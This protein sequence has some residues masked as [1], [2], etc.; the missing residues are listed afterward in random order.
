MADDLPFAEFLGR[1]RAGDGEAARELVRRYEP[2]IRREV[3][4][5]IGDDRLNRAFDSVDVSQSVLA[6]FFTRAA[7]GN[8]QIDRFEQ[9]AMLLM[10]MARNKLA[11]RARSER[12]LI[13]DSRRLS[14]KTEVLEHVV[15]AGPSPSEYLARR[16]EIA[17]L[18]SVLSDEER[19]IYELRIEGLSWDEIAARLGGNG[20]ARRM[21]FSRG[22]QRLERQLDGSDGA[23]K[24]AAPLRC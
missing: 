23:G 20:H 1:V 12:R 8:Y 2:L 19:T 16:E 18:K 13:R 7:S 14:A 17:R 22:L 15:D 11:S 5:R 24:A 6:S 3:R 4:L 21:Q 9:L 10:T